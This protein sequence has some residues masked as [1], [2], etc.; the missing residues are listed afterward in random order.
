MRPG[1]RNLITDVPGLLAGNAAD[2]DLK[3]GVTVVTSETPFTASVMVLGGAPGTRE[4]D[5]LEPGTL[6]ETVDALVLS[7]GSA[8]GLEA[9]AGVAATLRTE[10]RGFDVAGQRV[11]IVP[12]AILFD[13]ANG[14][15]KD[16]DENPY[17]ALG[18]AAYKSAGESFEIGTE[19][20]GTGATTA[21]LKGGL[22]SASL[23]LGNGAHVGALVAANPVG[24]V[25][26]ETGR[27][28]AAPF[29]QNAEFGGRGPVATAPPDPP[30]KLTARANTT[31]A[32]VA[33]DL[34][35]TKAQCRRLA[36]MAH[37][38]L[39]RAV[40]PSH[41]TFDGDCIF[42]ASTARIAP[43]DPDRDLAIAGDAAARCLS[44]AIARAVFTATPASGDRKPTWAD[45]FGT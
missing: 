22:G 38:G 45:T 40:V 5:L 33:T 9:G 20:A 37:A 6:V 28:W 11:P 41:T 24:A 39:A 16:W 21:T 14:G 7:G 30:T 15:A 23:A 31:I 42:A 34:A 2:P 36:I 29:E 26:D 44:R 12:G 32:I 10:G 13:L 19:G 18:R 1:P 25:V 8:F 35:F 43:G 17:P 4:T 3:S 27:F